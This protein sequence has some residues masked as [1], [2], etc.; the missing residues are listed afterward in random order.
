M[1]RLVTYGAPVIGTGQNATSVGEYGIE[2]S[3]PGAAAASVY[4]SHA[5]IRPSHTGH[6]RLTNA[7]LLNAKLFWL[8]LVGLN[9]GNG[10]FIAVPLADPMDFFPQRVQG[11]G[12]TPLWFEDHT[13]PEFLAILN[14]LDA[15]EEK[16][17]QHNP[18]DMDVDELRLDQSTGAREVGYD[19]VYRRARELGPD[20]NIVDFMFNF[21][22]SNGEVNKNLRLLNRFN[23][24]IYD[25]LHVATS[26][27]EGTR[28][29][30]D[31]SVGSISH[32]P[33]IISKTD[34]WRSTYG[35][36]FVLSF[37]ERLGVVETGPGE[38]EV[39][40]ILETV[41]ADPCS[42]G[43]DDPRTRESG[44]DWLDCFRKIALLRSVIMDPFLHT[45]DLR[46]DFFVHRWM[47]IVE[48]VVLD[49]VQGFRNADPDGP[50]GCAD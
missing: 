25:R 50:E 35:D 13:D 6:G 11:T 8:G 38:E 29:M 28:V 7:S 34:V 44:E 49:V 45:E 18:E 2:G 46:G 27:F 47:K 17:Q 16:L 1:R 40:N 26:D 5:V 33:V 20:L 48:D 39:R 15:L 4:V 22:R 31:R 30:P 3:K 36:E 23:L 42:S 14:K 19:S 21:R 32:L 24:A 37:L 9:K 10:D 12:E 43:P 41:P